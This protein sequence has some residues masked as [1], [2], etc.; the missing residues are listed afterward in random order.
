MDKLISFYLAFPNIPKSPEI[1]LSGMSDQTANC[2]DTSHFLS[3]IQ[4]KLLQHL[5]CGSKSTKVNF[6]SILKITTPDSKRK[7]GERPREGV[8]H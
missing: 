6:N 1:S 3:G 4:R 2:N 5:K 8:T 7:S